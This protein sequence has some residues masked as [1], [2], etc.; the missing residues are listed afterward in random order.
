MNQT[1]LG[2]L[3]EAMI[4]T[5]IGLAVTMTAAPII[6]PI[7][8]HSFTTAQ[9]FGIAAVFTVISVVRQYVVRRWFNARIHAAAMKLAAAAS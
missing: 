9:N 6:Y 5:I 1:R 8:G 4:S 3:I 7:F 2:S